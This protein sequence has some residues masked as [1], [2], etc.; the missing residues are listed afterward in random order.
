MCPLVGM[1]PVA[2]AFVDRRCR[3][4]ARVLEPVWWSSAAR[5]GSS[6]QCMHART[7]SNLAWWL[8]SVS[9]Q[10]VRRLYWELLK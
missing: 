5:W 8:R 6:G 9:S 10:N 3:P 7:C 4:G 2:N 1:A